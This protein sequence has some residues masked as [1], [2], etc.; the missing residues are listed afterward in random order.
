MRHEG[1]GSIAVA[2]DP[3]GYYPLHVYH[4]DGVLCLGNRVS[5]MAEALERLG[6][7]VPRDVTVHAWFTVQ[8]SAVGLPSA[9]RSIGLLPP[10][11]T[12]RVDPRNRVRAERRPVTDLLYAGRPFAELADEAAEEIVGNL[13]ALARGDF[14]HWVCDLTGGM[15]S[16]LVLAAVLGE[17]LQDALVFH[18]IGGHPNS[19]ANVAALIRRRF[20]LRRGVDVH[21][22]PS[23]QRTPLE[24]MRTTLGQT[25]GLMST[26]FKVA[27]APD[28]PSRHLWI[29]GGSGELLREFWSSGAPAPAPIPAPRRR[30]RR[31]LRAA[32]GRPAPAPEGSVLHAKAGSVRTRAR[33]LRPEAREAFAAAVEDFAR[34]SLAA[35]VAPEHV[36]DHYYLATRARYHFGV[37][38][39][40]S[41]RARFH[42][43]Y[44]PAA[45]R[46]AHALPNEEKAANRLGFEL[47]R[48]L[49]PELLRLPFAGKRW[50]PLVMPDAPEPVTRATPP[51]GDPDERAVSVH[52]PGP[53]APKREPSEWERRLVA[54]GAKS[55]EVE[56]GAA[57]EE[58]RAASLDW[59]ALEPVFDPGAVRAFL[60]RPHDAFRRGGDADD[61]YR[62]V[63]AALWASGREIGPA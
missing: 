10:G 42:P 43:L 49:R 14:D 63:A 59:E 35:G 44:S 37:F 11:A 19:D 18:T 32:L 39:A 22:A 60:D 4:R 16:R 30:L 27:P 31:L 41:P 46:A 61:A 5:R 34:D 52:P 7:P 36:G 15:D 33:L 24:W 1:D 45:L 54:R 26:F 13:R 47:M 50:P 38:W 57:L 9:R 17:G 58:A 51:L 3:F 28:A 56:L 48:R 55:R 40:T 23:V 20:G 21:P 62:V 2:I 8:G 53:R 25:G 29:G 6:R 12:I